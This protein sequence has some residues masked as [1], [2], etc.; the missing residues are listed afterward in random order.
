MGNRA[1]I[2]IH[3]ADKSEYSPI[4]YLHYGGDFSKYLKALKATMADRRN[5]VAYALARLTAI[6]CDAFPG[7]L[8]VGIMPLPA[9]FADTK[10]YLANLSHGDCGVYLV[11]ADTFKSRNVK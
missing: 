7:N 4:L 3:N 1:L 5:D 8:S 6:A 9:D 11:D 10:T 2:I